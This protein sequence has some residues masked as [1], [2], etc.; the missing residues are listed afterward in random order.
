[1]NPAIAV[2]NQMKGVGTHMFAIGV[3]PSISLNP[4]QAITNQFSLTA[5]GSN[6][7]WAGYTTT[8]DYTT[9][10]TTL[11]QIAVELCAPS[12]TVTKLA[13]TPG[14]TAFT[15][16]DGWVFEAGV[17]INRPGVS[18][19]AGAWVNPGT[20]PIPANTESTK[21]QTTINSGGRQLPVGAHWAI[22]RAPSA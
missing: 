20:D 14:S 16:A 17:T 22:S 18:G 11:K 10:A 19:Q 6:F 8:T 15:P 1:M 7:S 12:V 5:N 9:L 13:Q 4:I 21:P 3:G 2:A